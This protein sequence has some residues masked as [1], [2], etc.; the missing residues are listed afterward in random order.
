MVKVLP[1]PP[2]LA[3]CACGCLRTYTSSGPW[4]L[5]SRRDCCANAGITAIHSLSAQYTSIVLRRNSCTEA[6]ALLQ[7]RESCVVPMDFS[8]PT[9][10]SEGIVEQAL[11]S[12]CYFTR[13]FTL[14]TQHSH[15]WHPTRFNQTQSTQNTARQSTVHPIAAWIGKEGR[16]GLSA[17]KE[18]VGEKREEGIVLGRRRALVYI[19]VTQ[20][21][22][23]GASLPCAVR[24]PSGA[25]PQ[26]QG[27][28][29]TPVF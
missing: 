14:V 7:S 15:T 20:P 23:P 16:Q 8:T 29:G 1:D 9:A 26:T 10:W 13:A 2:P 21:L 4:V 19:P 5:Q 17:R 3:S 28:S 25:E 18:T 6:S 27:P 11:P 22:R 24:E 12:Q